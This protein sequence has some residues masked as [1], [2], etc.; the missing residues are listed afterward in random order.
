MVRL[1]LGCGFVG[2]RTVKA[3]VTLELTDETTDV[4]SRCR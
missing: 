2:L 3:W 1:R 4:V